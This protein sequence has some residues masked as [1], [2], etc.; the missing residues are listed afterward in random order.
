MKTKKIIGIT[1]SILSF[2]P[3]LVHSIHIS[4]FS[5]EEKKVTSYFVCKTWPELEIVNWIFLPILNFK[6]FDYHIH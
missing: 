5:Q 6:I 3:L 2:C 4:F 1:L